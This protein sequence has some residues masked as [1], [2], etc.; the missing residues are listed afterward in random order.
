MKAYAAPTTYL[1]RFGDAMELLCG[2]NRP[3]DEL[4]RDFL[5]QTGQPDNLQEFAIEHGPIWS[6]GIA[7]IDAARLIAYNPTEGINH[8]FDI[9]E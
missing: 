1:Q 8:G 5:N 2:G 3:P 9:G 6:Q 7:L 4:M